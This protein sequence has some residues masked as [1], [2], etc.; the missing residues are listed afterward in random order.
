VTLTKGQPVSKRS[1]ENDSVALFLVGGEIRATTADEKTTVALRKFGDAVYVPKGVEEKEDLISRSPPRPMVVEL[2]D[3]AVPVLANQ[4]GYPLAFPRPGSKKV[5]ENDCIVVW[6]FTWK[7]G[8]PTPMYYHDKDSVAIY[9]YNGSIR[10]TTPGGK[11]TVNDRKSEEVLF[12]KG[13]RVHF[14][15]L[16]K[17]Q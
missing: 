6:N 5:F 1:Q 7:L 11:P 16:V 14:E 17:G 3:N 13:D 2:K 8:V 10:S 15:E 4:S 9:M 12:S